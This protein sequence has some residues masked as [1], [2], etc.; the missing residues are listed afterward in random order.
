MEHLQSIFTQS[1]WS[2]DNGIALNLE[3]ENSGL[4]SGSYSGS[5][6]STYED[7]GYLRLYPDPADLT[8]SASVYLPLFDDGWWSV[9]INSGSTGYDLYAK[10]KI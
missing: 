2:T 9:L 10:N 4:T 8:V 5:I 6:V 7:Y 3:Y 1:L